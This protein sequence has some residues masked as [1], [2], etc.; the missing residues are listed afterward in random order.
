MATG[1]YVICIVDANTYKSFLK[2]EKHQK[3]KSEERRQRAEDEKREAEAECEARRSDFED[4]LTSTYHLQKNRTKYNLTP[5]CGFA[6]LRSKD[7]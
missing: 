3:Q 4:E 2:I 6:G 7:S 5:I 1:N